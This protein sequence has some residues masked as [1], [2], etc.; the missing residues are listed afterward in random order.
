MQ[1]MSEESC[2]CSVK[3]RF[4]LITILN[5]GLIQISLNKPCTRHSIAP[6]LILERRF[7]GIFPHFCHKVL[8]L[9]N[10]NNKLQSA[11]FLLDPKV[12]FQKNNMKVKIK[13]RQKKREWC[14]APSCF[15]HG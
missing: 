1:R 12:C 14:T 4:I 2:F 9:L 15:K 5:V 8:L 7:Y 11:M 3:L 13:I 10:N 6:S